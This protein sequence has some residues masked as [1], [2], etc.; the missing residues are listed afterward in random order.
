MADSEGIKVD[1]NRDANIA[2][3]EETN[4]KQNKSENFLFLQLFL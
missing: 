3:P 1:N 4:P 2:V